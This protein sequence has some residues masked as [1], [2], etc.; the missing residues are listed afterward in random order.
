VVQGLVC[1]VL[2]TLSYNERVYE[3]LGMNNSNDIEPDYFTLEEE[4]DS[5]LGVAPRKNIS[6]I[7]FWHIRKT[8]LAL[9]CIRCSLKLA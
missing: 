7:A 5:Y 8:H 2:S 1:Q 3:L 9:K 4:V 6:S